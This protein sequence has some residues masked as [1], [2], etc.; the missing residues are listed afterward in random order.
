MMYLLEYLIYGLR[1]AEDKDTYN[2]RF[3]NT[4]SC[5]ELRA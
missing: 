5:S 4:S 1:V 3:G 2:Q